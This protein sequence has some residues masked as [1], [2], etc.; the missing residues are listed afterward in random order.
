MGGV[1]THLTFEEYLAA[2]AFAQEGQGDAGAIAQALGLHVDDASWHEITL[3]SVGY[4]GRIQQLERVAGGVVEAL[5]TARPGAPGMATV[6]AGEAVLD[7]WPGGV[8]VSSKEQVIAALVSTMQDAAVS[9]TLRRRAG[10]VLGRLGWLPEDLDTFVEI[11]AGWFLYGENQQKQEIPYRYWIA[12]YPVTNLHYARFIEDGGYQCKELWSKAGWQWRQ[13]EQRE[14][15]GFWHDSKWNNPIF[16]VVGVSWY[17][18]EAYCRWLAAWFR[19]NGFSG[20]TERLALPEGYT[21]RLPT[22]EEWERAARGTDGREYPWG[23]HFTFA[24][25]NVAAESGESFGTTA[26]CTYPQGISPVGAWDLSGNVWEWTSSFWSPDRDTPVV[27]GGSWLGGQRNARCAYR[28]RY[29]PGYFYDLLGFR[30]V[31]S[32]ANS[33]C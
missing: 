25:A 22:E 4:V 28:Y 29:H 16:P 31:V 6:L 27:R 10:L 32:L 13:D 26:V 23:E 33:E 7:T 1:V 18:A 12:K 3:L 9:T 11:P 19:K 15:P 5:I 24:N 30:V 2:V 17:E 21:I 20:T 8:S 14:Q